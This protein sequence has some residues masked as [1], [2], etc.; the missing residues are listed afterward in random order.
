MR[1][2]Y[3]GH[4]TVLVEVGGSSIIIDPFLDGNPRAVRKARDVKV[5]YII[6][7]HGHADHTMDAVAIA[8]NNDATI[9]A[10]HEL[11]LYMEWQGAKTHGMG[12]GGGHRFPF[13]EVRLT[14]A[15]HS[16]SIDDEENQKFTYVGMPAG[17]ILS[18]DG[19]TMY[20][21][22]DTALFG[23]M[24]LIGEL[25]TPDVA[26]LPIGDNYTMGP[27]EAV[28]AAEWLQAKTVIPIHYNTFP[29]IEQDGEQFVARLKQKGIHGIALQPEEYYDVE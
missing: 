14:Q 24:K 8:K 5:D 11:A 20:H 17:I 3:I 15:F 13:G 25:Y 16:S 23:D 29:L 18:G 21:A 1:I 4:S 6:L 19:K 7:T 10:A 12:L 9:I 28:Y 26:L 22:G 2:T 27:R